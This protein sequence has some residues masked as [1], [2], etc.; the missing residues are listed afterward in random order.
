MVTILVTGGRGHVARAVVGGL[1]AAGERVR[2]AS[3]SPERAMV[4]SGVETVRADLADPATLSAA[5]EGVR[6]VFLY[7]DAR[8][9]DGFVAAAEAAGSPDV[10]LL[11]ALG[12]DGGDHTRDPIVRMHHTA[13]DTLRRSALAWT[14]LRP[15]AFATN[16]LQWAPAIRAT[17][18]VEAPYPLAHAASVH[19]ADIAD[20]AVLALTEDGHRGR[21][22]PLTGPASVTQQEQVDCLS[23][24]T[25]R[26]IVLAEIGPEE[27][28]ATLHQWGDEEM[29][30]TLLGHLSDADNRP[31]TVHSTYQDLMGRPGRTYAQWALDHADDF[32]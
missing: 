2:V 7:A 17:G 9:L 1:L 10:V 26:K 12:A 15:G 18:T 29:V 3:R 8:G 30:D 24:A 23:A 5:L 31:A 13:E 6:K 11:S 27:Y 14:F 16:T 32:R 28:R 19:E 4:P 25:G 20:V 21:V 22:H